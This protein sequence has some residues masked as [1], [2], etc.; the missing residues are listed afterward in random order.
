VS[1][2]APEPTPSAPDPQAQPQVSTPPVSPAPV[3]TSVSTGA[4]GDAETR[5]REWQSRYDKLAQEHQQLQG[6]LSAL[7]TRPQQP[8]LSLEEIEARV[9]ATTLRVHKLVGVEASLR[10]KYPDVARFRGELFDLSKY[11]SPEAFEAAVESAD[12]QL[13]TQFADRD[14][15]AE[16]RVRAEYEK[17]FG[18]LPAPPAQ[19][20]GPG[21]LS[22]DQVLAM[23]DSELDAYEAQHGPG[24]ADRLLASVAG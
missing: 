12:E 4:G 24:S 14:A 9:A 16:A 11:E 3:P 21:E 15:A 10:E 8:S 7:E 17:R 5:I 2:H 23:S 6:R 13:K 18:K 22:V 20:T 1:E 19:P